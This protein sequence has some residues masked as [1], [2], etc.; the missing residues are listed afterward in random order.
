MANEKRVLSLHAHPDDTEFSCAGTLALLHEKG[1]EV[2]IAT[3]TPG[4]CGSTELGREQI[5]KIRRSE[6]AKSADIL[7]EVTIVLNVTMSLFFM[8]NQLC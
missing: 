7:L 3:M 4:D 1:W 6:A 5:S 2:C 8:T